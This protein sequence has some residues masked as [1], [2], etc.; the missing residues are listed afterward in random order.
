MTVGQPPTIGPAPYLPP[1]DPVSRYGGSRL[2]VGVTYAAPIGYRP[3][4]LDLWVPASVA[5]P[6]LVVWVHGGGW[7]FGDGSI[8]P[9]EMTSFNHYALG[10]VADW[11]HRTIAGLAPA[12]PGYRRLRVAPRPG[13]GLTSARATHETPYGPAAVSWTLDGQSFALDVTV[14]PNT[15]AQVHLPDG[16]PPVEVGSGRYRLACA[17]PAPGT[18]RPVSKPGGRLPGT[19]RPAAGYPPA[20][21][22]V[23]GPAAVV[24]PT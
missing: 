15:A 13:G 9:G 3:L 4:Q 7:L 10:A 6:P 19:H 24:L 16:R 11:M 2:F 8:N 17:L 20:G 23:A 22:R 18:S 5:P 1:P 14:P 12:A 21:A